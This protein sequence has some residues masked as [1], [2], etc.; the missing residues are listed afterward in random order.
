MIIIKRMRR[1]VTPANILFVL[2]V[3][4][5][6]KGGQLPTENRIPFLVVLGLV[7][8]GSLF[9]LHRLHKQASGDLAA[10]LFALL[11]LW[12]ICTTQLALAHRILIPPPEDV[13][14]VFVSQHRLMLQ[15]VVS[16]LQLLAVGFG[17]SLLLGVGLGLFAGWVPRLREVALP[18]A[19]VLSPIPSII[20][21]PYIIA[22]MP[23]FRSASAMVI[24][25]GLFWPT[26]LNTIHR[27]SSVDRQLIDTARVLQVGTKT[28]IFQI[29]LPY[30]L[31][32]VI[33]GLKV[34]LSTSFMILMLAEMMGA[35]SGLGYFI[36]V[37]ADYANYTNVI[38]GI[39]LVGVVVTLLNAC[40][41]VLEKKS[42]RWKDAA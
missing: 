26:F 41:S 3:A 24:I 36:K 25:L 12:E 4:L 2:L 9:Y 22:L 34:S 30:I 19:R 23:T 7:E 33:T 11:L 32:G 16:S 27:V 40:L 29:L 13:F 15:G 35:K 6:V 20:Y 8:A 38:A 37:Y 10:I 1:W 31:P 14:L 5:V 28:M 39:I 17:V 18:L 21:A 42:I